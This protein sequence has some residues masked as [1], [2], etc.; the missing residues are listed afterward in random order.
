MNSQFE[1]SDKNTI[2]W[3]TPP[4]II[5][6]LGEFDLDPCTSEIAYKLNSSAKNYYTKEDDGLSKEWL[7][8]V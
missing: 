7:G 4:E 3:Y 6:S 8:R 5:R 2:E 1:R